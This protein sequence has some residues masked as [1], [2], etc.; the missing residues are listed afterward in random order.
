ML[1]AV[2]YTLG[3]YKKK[4]TPSGVDETRKLFPSV[5]KKSR[6]GMM[7]SGHGRH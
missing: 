5:T 2:F 3:F 7:P 6:V 1:A 4:L